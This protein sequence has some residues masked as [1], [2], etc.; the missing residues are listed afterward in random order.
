MLSANLLYTL[1]RENVRIG[2]A[3]PDRNKLSPTVS[4]T[5][6][7]FADT[8]FR[9]RAFYKNI[10]RLP[11][12]NDLYYQEIGNTNLRPENAHQFNVGFTFTDSKMPFLSLLE[13]TTDAYYNRITDKIISTP[14]DLFYWSMKNIG[15]VAIK[16]LDVNLKANSKIGKLGEIRFLTNYSYQNAKDMT[17]NTENYG[18]QIPYTPLHAGST[19][20]SYSQNWWELG[21]NFQFTGVRWVGQLTDNRNKMEAYTTHSVYAN[22]KYKSW[23][24]KTELL[25]VLNTQY[26]VVKFYPMPRRNFRITAAYSF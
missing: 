7:P 17:P 12:F 5:F 2:L 10:F 18:E 9:I 3:A 20:L 16:G 21:Y 13:L 8:D 19:S 25:N 22:F 15:L 23:E 14:R 1:T 26:E 4:A 11:T 6:K 24:L